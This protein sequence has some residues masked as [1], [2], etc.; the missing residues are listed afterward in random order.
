MSVI[1]QML[2]DLEQRTPEQGALPAVVPVNNKPSTLKIVSISLV[3]LLSLN[4]LGFYIWDLQKRADSNE[5]KAKEHE[6]QTIASKPKQQ[7]TQEIKVTEVNQQVPAQQ[8]VTKVDNTAKNLTE[9]LATKQLETSTS[10]LSVEPVAQE[11][12]N[13]PQPRQ[14]VAKAIVKA[15][16]P[17]GEIA[18]S[19]VKDLDNVEPVAAEIAKPSKM[20]VSRR[21]LTTKELVAQKLARAE[22]AV[23]TNQITKA[24]KL[25]EEVLILE[26]S[27]Q[28]ARK[29][30]A[31]LWF[32]RK[33]YQ[34][35]VNL[36]SQGIALDKQDSELRML[37]ARIQ[38]K[39][40][41]PKGAYNTLKALPELAQQDYQ[42][43][44]A[45]VAQQVEAYDSAIKAYQVL[46]NMQPYSGKWHLGLAIV[47]DKNSEFTLAQAEY[48]LALSKNDLSNASAEFATQRMQ[49]LGE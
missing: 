26:P 17:T 30:L 4:A 38:M 41:Q 37:K 22:K 14:D 29:K 48:A 12:E 2:K 7:T 13:S 27:H 43:M 20:T 28:Q 31:A 44:L 42:V 24:E 25:F 10:Q 40:G 18:Q 46:I 33:S 49:A 11:S 34:Q 39:Q 36:L 3:V 5:L 1:N 19:T 15:P 16:K 9:Q 35:A 45:N 21:Q 8:L 32:G 6:V 23:N 47:Y